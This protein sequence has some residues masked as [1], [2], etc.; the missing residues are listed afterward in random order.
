VAPA[1]AHGPGVRVSYRSATPNALTIEV[2]QTVHFQNA[3]SAGGPCTV[4]EDQGA[5]ESPTLGR[6]EG[7]H[8]T[9]TQPGSFAYHVREFPGVKGTILVVEP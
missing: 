3:N 5:F 7:W 1:L 6:A 8:Y 4:I 2:G 9:F